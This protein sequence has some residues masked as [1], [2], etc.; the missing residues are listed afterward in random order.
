MLGLI[1]FKGHAEKTGGGAAVHI[2][3]LQQYLCLGGGNRRSPGP[4]HGSLW[5]MG[6]LLM[7]VSITHCDVVG[8]R[9]LKQS[10]H[11]SNEMHCL[12]F[13][14]NNVSLLMTCTMHPIANIFLFYFQMLF[15]YM[16]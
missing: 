4:C 12:L 5:H 13:L 9:V 16:A 3:L 15:A 7:P 6:P 1:G 8:M 2:T 11:S 14:V 10:V